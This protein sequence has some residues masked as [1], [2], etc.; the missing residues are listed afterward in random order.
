MFNMNEQFANVFKTPLFANEQF[1]TAVKNAFPLNGQFAGFATSAYPTNELLI[2][3]A[4]ANAEAGLTA[5]N[6]LTAKALESMEKVIDLNLAAAKA[7]LEESAT[8]PQQLL[9][10]KDPQEFISTVT[11]LAQPTAAKAVAYNRHL[12]D[13]LVAAQGEFNRI[14]NEQFAETRRQ[15]A[16]LV[17]QVA[18]QAPAGSENAFAVVKAA[19][20]N[21][22]AGYEQIAKTASQAA[23]VVEGNVKNAVNQVTQAVEQ[24]ATTASA[25]AR[26][27]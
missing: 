7:S 6:A 15:F 22:N 19:I 12:A 18:K 5:L 20:D 13:I 11:A 4:K 8:I 27:Q 21:A 16:G 14:A 17:D 26:K 24:T 25:R 9:S 23:E 3:A 10:S 1:I 2:K